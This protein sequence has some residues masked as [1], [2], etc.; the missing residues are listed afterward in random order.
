VLAG[1]PEILC[2]TYAPCI[3]C[4]A[5]LLPHG[6]WKHADCTQEHLI[7]TTGSAREPR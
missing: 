1:G 7:H 3:V 2:D 4:G 6:W 5:A